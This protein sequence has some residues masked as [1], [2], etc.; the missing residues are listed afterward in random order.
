[1]IF[2]LLLIFTNSVLIVVCLLQML[3]LGIHLFA[4]YMANLSPAILPS[5][6]S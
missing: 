4:I 2:L 3:F 6:I 1:M 5:I